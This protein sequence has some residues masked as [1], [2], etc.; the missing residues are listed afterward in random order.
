MK[1]NNNQT[2]DK[3]AKYEKKMA[4]YRNNLRRRAY[5]RALEDSHWITE[6]IEVKLSLFLF[7]DTLYKRL[8]IS[9]DFDVSIFLL[10][11]T[12]V[13]SFISFIIFSF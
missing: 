1:N 11:G 7:L 8:D 2:V 13:H 9:I 3:L 5:R 12:N 10:F 6:E 4:K